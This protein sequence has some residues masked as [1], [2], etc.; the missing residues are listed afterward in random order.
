MSHY[1]GK[2]DTSNRE[3]AH[4]RF[5]TVFQRKLLQKS[6]QEDLPESY[7]QRIQIMLLVDEGKSQTEICRTLGCSPATARHWTHIA[8]TGMAHQWQDC[9][10]GRPITVNDEYLKRLQQLVSNSPRDYGYSFQRWT[11][12]WLKKHLAKEFGVEVS[13]RHIRRLL[14]Q[15]GL[16]TRPKPK[17]TDKDTNKN[18][19]ARSSKILIR[20]LNSAN[21]PDSTELLPINLTKLGTDS[22]IYGAQSNTS[23]LAFFTTVEQCFRAFSF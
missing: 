6:L 16:S 21:P 8:R 11:A 23:A 1:P 22:D 15:M 12:N 18:D 14:Q 17:N 7:R 4:N 3:V 19:L 13:D 9:P 10:I 2:F 20:D 5:L